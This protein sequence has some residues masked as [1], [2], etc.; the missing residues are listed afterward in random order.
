MAATVVSVCF[1]TEVHGLCVCV[2]V[3]REV[4]L[5]VCACLCTR[6]YLCVCVCCR[7]L[8]TV[9]VH[10]ASHAVGSHG[11]NMFEPPSDL[12]ASLQPTQLFK[13]DSGGG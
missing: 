11:K 3:R 2:C 12:F 9:P 7:G 5:Y 13:H 10:V 4:G 6:V 1:V 8:Y